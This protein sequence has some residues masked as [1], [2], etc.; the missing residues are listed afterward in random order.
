MEKKSLQLVAL[1]LTATLIFGCSDSDSKPSAK[2]SKP[3]V[4]DKAIAYGKQLAQLRDQA[5]SLEQRLEFAKAAKIWQQVVDQVS[6][7]FGENS[8]QSINAKV[9]HKSAARNQHLKADCASELKQ[10]MSLQ[11]KIRETFG[12]GQDQQALDLSRQLLALQEPLYGDV[13]MD[14]ARLKLQIGSLAERLGLLDL[15]LKNLHSGIEIFRSKGIELH[16]ELEVSL[17][18]LANL[19]GKQAKY[20]PAVANQKA[21][22]Q[23][24]GHIWGTK[25]LQ[26][27]NQANQLG[28]LFHQAGN[29]DV[30]AGILEES[31]MIREQHLGDRSIE[32]AQSCLNLGIVRLAQ[33]KLDLAD[34]L[35]NQSRTLFVEHFGME[36]E[37]SIRCCSQLATVMMLSNRP[38]AAEKLLSDI[39][40]IV[41]ANDKSLELADY[42]YK[43]AIALARQA[44]YKQGEPLFLAALKQQQTMFGAGSDQAK[45]TMLALAKMYEATHQKQKLTAIRKKLNQTAHLASGN[46]FQPRY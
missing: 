6:A 8:W 33:Q 20:L 18:T 42:Q 10:I 16:P 31:K 15:A 43:L 46:D 35:L 40:E 30:A 28:V 22:V 3:E 4:S 2:L 14:T 23:I 9:A 11:H 41:G 34:Q 24:A 21:A 38:E 44:K 7:E 25:S 26:Y 19:Y 37:Y 12:R 17:A 29:E 45:T 32:F 39:V 27:A 36:N 1:L 13:S 5:R